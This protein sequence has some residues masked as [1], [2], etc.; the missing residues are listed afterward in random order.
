M[1]DVRSSAA[2]EPSGGCWPGRYLPVSTPWAMGDHTIWPMPSVSRHRD[3]LG[4][5]DPPQHRVLRLVGDDAVEAHVTGDAYR[6]GD[7]RRRPL[8]HPDVQHL[9]RRDEVVEGPQGLLQRRLARRSGGPGTGRCSRHRAG[10]ATP[11]TPSTRC[12]RDRPRSFGPGPTGQYTLVQISRPSRRWPARARP[13]TASA[14]RAG[15]DVGGVEGGDALVQGR[16]H[17]G[18]GGVLFDLVAVGQPVA[19]RDL[20]D[21]QA[22]ASR[23]GDAPSPGR[24]RAEPSEVQ[25]GDGVAGEVDHDRRQEPDHHGE[26]QR[27]RQPDGGR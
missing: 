4:L 5:D 20:R 18:Q 2:R 15:V 11:R 14:R 26:G 17:A 24:Y 8:R 6:V 3:D 13:S 23:D 19:V 16:L 12:L 10:A 7:L 9:A 21:L 22:A 25:R 27:Q 1:V